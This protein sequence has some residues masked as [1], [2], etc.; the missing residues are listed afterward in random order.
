MRYD[1]LVFGNYFFDQIFTG[2]LE[3]PSLG[4]EAHATKL[5]TTG[6]AMFIT[7]TALTRLGVK[8]G[9]PGYFGNDSYSRFAYEMAEREGVDLTLAKVADRPFRQV[10]SSIPYLGERAFLAYADPEPDEL[11]DHWLNSMNR[12]EFDHIHFGGWLPHERMQPLIEKACTKGATVSSDCQDGSHL[13]EPCTCRDL[14]PQIDI[15]MPNA[16][17]ALVVAG[18]DTVEEAVRQLMEWVNVVVVKDGA[19]GAWIGH[20]GEI[21]HLPAIDAGDVVDTTGAGDCFNAGFLFGYLMEKASLEVCGRYGNICGGLSVTDIG[22]AT[23]APT[24]E[25]LK[26]W[27]EKT[28]RSTV[29]SRPSA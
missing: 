7:A 8:V 21:I 1:V 11:Y 10:T 3:F 12:C 28:G 14:L 5:T 17:E 22:G 20:E 27:L 18:R 2:L 16:R 15:F 6:G 23:A 19:N 29:I 4:K 26:S 13:Q 9:W 25:E 24:H